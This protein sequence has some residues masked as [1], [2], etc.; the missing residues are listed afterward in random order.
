M[1]SESIIMRALGSSVFVA[2]FLAMWMLSLFDSINILWPWLIVPVAA[3][4]G[5]AIGV[6]WS[7]KAMN[8]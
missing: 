3:I 2:I 6:I 5:A 1:S 4:S 7:V 8:Q